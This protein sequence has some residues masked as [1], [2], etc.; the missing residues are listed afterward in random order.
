MTLTG[1]RLAI[2]AALSTATGVTGYVKRPAT[3]K[4]GDAWPM[5]GPMENVGQATFEI[6]WR[7]IVFLPQDE[8][9]S[10]EWI[11]AHVDALVDAL[12]GIG[13]VDRIE[14]VE[15]TAGGTGQYALQLTMR[16]E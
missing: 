12:L 11:D 3:P 9:T 2:A 15:L 1:D 8:W 7:V 14:P 16:S 5:L 4:T 6:T 13:Q 10:S